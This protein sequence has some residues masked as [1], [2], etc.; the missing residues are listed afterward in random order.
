MLGFRMADC[1]NSF[2]IKGIKT[3]FI[4]GLSFIM[5]TMT[6]GGRWPGIVVYMCVKFVSWY[7]INFYGDVLFPL[8]FWYSF[9]PSDSKFATCSDDGTVRIWDF[10]KCHEEKILRGMLGYWWT[11]T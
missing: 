6:D 11:S 2:I 5:V 10:M 3:S 1:F 4:E 8:F 7:L 9:C